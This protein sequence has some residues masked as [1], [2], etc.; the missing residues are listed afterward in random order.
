LITLGR[1]LGNVCIDRHDESLSE[2]QV[3]KHNAA[4][5]KNTPLGE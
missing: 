2:W 4:T 5:K 1:V 3:R